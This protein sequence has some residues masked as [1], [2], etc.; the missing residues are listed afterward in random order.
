MKIAKLSLH[1]DKDKSFIVHNESFPFAPF[2]HHH[3]Y[4]MVLIEKGKG[5]RMVGDNVDRFQKNDLVFTGPFLPHQWIPDEDASQDARAFV[6]QFSYDFLG[7]KFFEIPE[8][9][10][11]RKFLHESVRGFTFFGKTKQ[12]IISIL[13]K[14]KN[15]THEERL[16]NLLSIF[17]IFSGTR[18]TIHLSSPG[19]IESFIQKDNEMMQK[20]LQYILQNFQ[21]NIQIDQLL[22]ITNM[23]YS[24]FYS[25]FYRDFKMTYKQYLLGVR[26]D[27]ACKL[28][29]NESLSISGIAY[30]CGFGNLS[31]FN[32][33]FR[34]AKKL[35]PS[36][37]Q[38]ELFSVVSNDDDLVDL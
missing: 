1:Q 22:E 3:E 28:L 23:S 13:L 9:A 7:D 27:Y 38:K 32:R 21:N 20:A 18:E 16:Y 8:N 31:N 5:K 35:T 37:F 34:K 30:S 12:Q 19:S 29:K 11:V 17:K 14:M 36:Q 26:L 10:G 25:H 6:I 2:H 4:E 24:T 15:S 33:Q